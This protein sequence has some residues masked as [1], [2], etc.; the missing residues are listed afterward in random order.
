MTDQIT[1][2]V[3]IIHFCRWCLQDFEVDVNREQ[4]R[5]IATGTC[6]LTCPYCKLA[7]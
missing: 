3:E 1:E 4:L 6:C 7:C 2:T 5:L